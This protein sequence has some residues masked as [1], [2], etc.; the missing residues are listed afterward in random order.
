MNA[1]FYE[2]HEQLRN[3]LWG[4][5]AARPK[6][7]LSMAHPAQ[8]SLFVAESVTLAHVLRPLTLAARLG[9]QGHPV[10]F[11]TS[12][13]FRPWVEKH[14]LIFHPI[15][16]QSSDQFLTRLDRAKSVV[17]ETLLSRQIA[18]DLELLNRVR[19]S[20]VIGDFRLSLNISARVAATPYLGIV[21]AYWCSF[22]PSTM[23]LP[24]SP[25][26]RALGNPVAS[27]IYSLV[28]TWIPK[29]VLKEQ[30]GGIN[31]L[32]RKHH[33]APYRYLTDAYVDADWLALADIP[34]LFPIP[35]TFQVPHTYLGP[36][37]GSPECE[38]P[39]WW[40]QLGS[41]LPIIYFNLGSSG[42]QE[43]VPQVLDSLRGLQARWMVVS[44]TP[45][46]TRAPNVYWAR[47]LPGHLA[48]E[49]ADLLI[50]NGGAPSVNQALAAGKPVVGITRNFDQVIH[51]SGLAR[52]EFA[53]TFRS[54]DLDPAE[55]RESVEHLL[56]DPAPRE[57]ARRIAS[58][59]RS[60]DVQ[61]R[62]DLACRCLLAKAVA[63]TPFTRGISPD[64]PL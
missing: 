57:A 23:P 51:M 29:R 62:F 43:I 45:P 54:W 7:L 38:L 47:A 24:E 16:C 2:F 32:R 52:Q 49:R 5:E 10:H 22:D 6:I 63:A 28:P 46:A 14:G 15:Q 13:A 18:E 39:D 55:L 41:D 26:L 3:P 53:R 50:C 34:E 35:S 60:Y 61:S 58:V 56:R 36:L 40:D 27:R 19:P 44:P 9:K 12:E 8:N 59:M 17:D 64:S 11:A 31:R 1:C 25:F 48:C 20:L 21:N 42:R 33:L 30:A 4:R 37:S